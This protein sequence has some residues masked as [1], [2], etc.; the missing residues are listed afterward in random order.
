MRNRNFATGDLNL[1]SA[2]ITIGFPLFKDKPIT[3][4]ASSNGADYK[5]F[6]FDFHSFCG[7]YEVYQISDAWRKGESFSI[8]R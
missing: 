3:L 8:T 2:L 6:H 1:A 7:K 4:V 5:R